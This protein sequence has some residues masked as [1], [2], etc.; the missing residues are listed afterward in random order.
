MRSPAWII[1]TTQ[2]DTCNYQKS[3][4]DVR[5][6]GQGRQPQAVSGRALQHRSES[7]ATRRG[8]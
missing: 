2:K 7:C 4:V 8:R 6:G 3:A 1:E 5:G